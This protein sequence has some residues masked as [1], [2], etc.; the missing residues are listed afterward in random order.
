MANK[1]FENIEIKGF[2]GLGVVPD[3]R[4]V[5]KGHGNTGGTYNSRYTNSSDVELFTILNSG[6]ASIAKTPFGA[7]GVGMVPA[8]T[9]RLEVKGITSGSG[10]YA[11]TLKNVSS[12]DVLTIRDDGQFIAG[13][14]NKIEIGAAFGAKLS[15]AG[16][17]AL[18]ILDAYSRF[19]QPSIYGIGA[20][21]L[22]LMGD[23][24]AGTTASAVNINAYAR[25]TSSFVVRNGIKFANVTSGAVN[26]EPDLYLQYDSPTGKVSI[27]G[28]APTARLHV[29]GEGDTS[30]TSALK[31]FNSSGANPLLNLKNNGHLL[32]GNTAGYGSISIGHNTGYFEY[33][34]GNTFLG[35]SVA[36][37]FTAYNFGTSFNTG[38]GHSA[39]YSLLTG[40]GNVA[41][42]FSTLFALT[43]GQ[44]NTAIGG[45]AAQS[46]TTGSTNIAI[47]SGSMYLLTTG[48]NN[49]AIGRE[50]LRVTTGS[51]N[52]A[53]GN[54]AGY[55][56][57]GSDALYI[58]N[59]FVANTTL[60]KASA[61]VYGIMSP[62]TANQRFQIN[63]LLKITQGSPGAGKVLTSDAT[64]LATWQTIGALSGLV[65]GTGTTNYA[66]K[67]TDGPGSDIGD[68]SWAYSGTAYYPVTD[69]A[70]IGLTG[71]NRVG[72]IF[73]ASTIDYATTMT[74]A[75]AGSTKMTI[76]TGGNVGIGTTSPGQKLQVE[77][78]STSNTAI[79]IK[80]TDTGGKDWLVT[81]SGTAPA[82]G[83]G[84]LYLHNNTDNIPAI[85]M[86]PTGKITLGGSTSTPF[87]GS[88]TLKVLG[89]TL[90]TGVP[91]LSVYRAD[92]T[93]P[94]TIA[95]YGNNSSSAQ[96]LYGYFGSI[97][98]VNTASSE[99]GG[100]VWWAGSGG[101][102][103]SEKMRFTGEGRLGIATTNPKELLHVAGNITLGEDTGN[104][105]MFS[106]N[107]TSGVVYSKIMGYSSPS[108]RAIGFYTGAATGTLTERMTVTE[109]GSIGIGYNA[110]TNTALYV[111]SISGNTTS[112]SYAAKF[113]DG[114]STDLFN[115][116][117]DGRIG[118]G[119]NNNIFIGHGT[120]LVATSNYNTIIGE[121][122]FTAIATGNANTGVGQNV[123][124][125]NTSG[126]SNSALGVNA[127]YQNTTGN[128]NTAMG[129]TALTGNAIRNSAFGSGSLGSHVS[130]DLNVAVGWYALQTSTVAA[131]STA[132]G[133]S[134]QSG[135][136]LGLRN[137]SVGYAS[138][139]TN[140]TGNDN[141]AIGHQA[142]F[143]NVGSSNVFIG[144]SAGY[145]Q[146]AVSDKL[147]IDNQ[148]RADAA[149]DISKALVYGQFNA[150][151][152]SQILTFN[153][154]V[155]INKTA[156]ASELEVYASSNPFVN[157][158]AGN[159]GTFG[160]RLSRNGVY[161][162]PAKILYSGG[163]LFFNPASS[164]GV[165]RINPFGDG[166][167]TTPSTG[168]QLEVLV[169]SQ[170]LLNLK[171]I[172][173][174]A[175]N[176]LEDS[177][178][179][180]IG[181]TYWNGSTSIRNDFK[182]FNDAINTS[183]LT[184]LK[185]GT[186]INGGGVTNRVS[187][188][189]SGEFGIGV[190]IPTATLHS[191]SVSGNTTSGTYAA[192]IQNGS[193]VDLFN[194]RD[195]GYIS[196][197]ISNGNLTIGLGSGFA[198]TS[199]TFIG[200]DVARASNITSADSNT[201]V[202]WGALRTITSGNDNT[203]VGRVALWNITTGSDNTAVGD[204][205]LLGITTTSSNS[206]FGRNALGATSGGSLNSA[207]GVS[208]GYNTTGTRNS[209]FGI[210]AGQAN[211][212][213]SYNVII[214]NTAGILNDG[215]YNIF[216]G[217]E[218]GY[219]ETSA[220]NKLV[221]WNNSGTSVADSDARA[222]ITGTMGGNPS[223]QSL[224][225][226][227]RVEINNIS[228]GYSSSESITKQAA[229]QTLNETPVTL[230]SVALSNGEM[231]TIEARV[232]GYASD[233]S[234]ATGATLFATF[235][236]TGGTVTQVDTTDISQKDDFA[237]TPAITLVVDG[238]AGA[239]I[240]VASP[241]VSPDV[242]VNWVV[243]YTYHK[244]LTNS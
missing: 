137:T 183:G 159:N 241:A 182:I 117:N 108:Y 211:T 49:V 88:N 188:L 54:R 195:D 122:A 103:P 62:T 106:Q 192:K 90:L 150:A 110:P 225:F 145:Y 172:N 162:D 31:V 74:F 24:V 118:A 114:S 234:A 96:T 5:I 144:K 17:N 240:T 13:I 135:G 142:G 16:G 178:N 61:L 72:T 176:T 115:V 221:I 166:D 227:S 70:N 8:G 167:A 80:N 38:V 86:S 236:K 39:L 23:G 116:R 83:A 113:Q 235:R 177:A 191:R 100:F 155:G 21:G 207:F 222:I 4:L 224:R 119:K 173:A 164:S 180:M 157:I 30:S 77:S 217:N 7:L 102:A 98:I 201:G 156:P 226:N 1:K 104:A 231:V 79:S 95:F 138:I 15:T 228:T 63:G 85:I 189:N 19:T 57:T 143:T 99:T 198:N 141:T 107:L 48:S 40:S 36:A 123:L 243:T 59:F 209:F 93:N 111:R 194:V 91:P 199:N 9:S 87:D 33:V 53:L 44:S 89:G 197:G 76:L 237:V 161:D 28:V 210:S 229:I 186:E 14:G 133:A 69:G 216:I 81:T 10:T 125:G 109:D 242:T 203:A 26:E 64:G 46:I 32:L 238:T 153:A 101:A 6:D 140:T 158:H 29:K 120:G 121:S 163:G 42:G 112:A 45:A 174:T 67:W 202:G 206:A 127:L 60:E 171:P 223:V 187:L 124:D 51:G 75:E 128:D 132:V 165:F 200:V 47:G 175:G 136:T 196:A 185:I 146:V 11:A 149:G 94:A 3:S 68:S 37:S 218:A 181:S 170:K 73:M 58:S 43:S 152:A 131:E 168:Y 66:T 205:A 55:W 179:L 34:D 52:I 233:F 232:N 212:A 204:G 190:A 20:S 78:S 84:N 134:S 56:E 169:N 82:L 139:A 35:H 244:T 214:G 160:I 154:S 147:F 215:S 129:Y 126:A 50:A 92:G 25:V 130:G 151:P 193:S 27:G 230:T 213:G 208:A 219:R 71:T 105:I 97:P 220:S 18:Q 184:A 22:T 12:V 41:I 239:K 65:T 2:L 148:S